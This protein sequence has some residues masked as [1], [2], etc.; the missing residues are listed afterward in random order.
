MASEVEGPNG[1]FY[2][3][4]YSVGAS[5]L[6]RK[7]DV[8][9]VQFYL[10]RIYDNPFGGY[11]RPDPSQVMKVDGSCGPITKR[12]ILDF[13]QTAQSKDMQPTSIVPDGRVDRVPHGNAPY[14][15]RTITML[16]KVHSEYYGD[17]DDVRLSPEAPSYLKLALGKS[18]LTWGGGV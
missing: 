10:K 1:R 18:I 6:N 14:G 17:D 16:N 4:D 12:W 15:S 8:M 2:T 9:L 7:D 3:V 5:G 13:Q 11:S